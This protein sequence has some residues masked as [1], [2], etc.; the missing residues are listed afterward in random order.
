M[1]SQDKKNSPP[2]DDMQQTL[3][4][5]AIVVAV[6]GVFGLTKLAD[7]GKVSGDTIWLGISVLV[8]VFVALIALAKRYQQ[9]ET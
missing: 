9:D 1:S 6:G 3:A 2:K 8:A 7:S 5:A 4:I